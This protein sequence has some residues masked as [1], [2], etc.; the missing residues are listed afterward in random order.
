MSGI[1]K[2]FRSHSTQNP[3]N[4]SQ[5]KIKKDN[6][7]SFFAE[8]LQ[9]KLKISPENLEKQINEDGTNLAAKKVAAEFE[10]SFE[11]FMQNL[12]HKPSE[13]SFVSGGIGEA[14]YHG[15]LV[16]AMIKKMREG[17]PGPIAKAIEEQIKNDESRDKNK[18]AITS[19]NE[20][21]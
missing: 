7:T 21:H 8:Q 5:V 14:I 6:K 17:N 19:Y 4:Q 1:N 15:P 11:S 9:Q 12:Q 10:M 16:E 18:S 2:A 20:Q 3:K 13:D